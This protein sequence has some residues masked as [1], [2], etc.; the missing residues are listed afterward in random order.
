[1]KKRWRQ[2]IWLAVGAVIIVLI[3]YNLRRSPEWR[4]FRWQRLWATILEARL[5]LLAWGIAVVI[6]TYAVRAYR[7][8]C[9]MNPI[10]RASFWVLF[11]GQVLGFSSIY[12]IGRPGEFVRPAYIAKKE[13]APISAMMAVWLLE[14][15]FDSFFLVL[16][17]AAALYFEPVGPATPHGKSV[18]A[19]MHWGGNV[20]FAMMA[21]LVVGLVFL[22]LYADAV[23]NGVVRAL[24]FL[25]AH[26]LGHLRHFLASFAQGLEVIHDW[27]E[28]LKSVASTAVLWIMN[29]TVFWLVFQALGGETAQLLWLAAGLA[30]F[31]AAL[32]LII[33][34]PGIGGGY[35]V[36][37]I[38]ALTGIFDVSAERATG[39]AILI[40]II[41][42]VPCLTMG[43]LMLIHEGLT[44][45]KL[46]AIAEEERALA[47]EEKAEV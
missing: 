26:A 28:L 42:F 27:R 45:R 3:F 7:W 14:R 12:L 31:C 21:L 41:M 37:I 36:G 13:N 8:Q 1:M 16:L 40:W 30:L 39:A 15:I 17:F 34:F 33:Q 44:F 24:R 6:A 25:P 32:G 2:W 4:D 43:L 23:V 35:Q 29:T 22:R 20:L 18:L 46:E 38:L 5:G 9:F 19:T 11:A 10:Q 47:E